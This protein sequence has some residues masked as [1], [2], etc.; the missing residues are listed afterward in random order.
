MEV[1]RL[2]DFLTVQVE[3]QSQTVFLSAKDV[4]ADGSKSWKDYT[5]QDVQTLSDKVSQL[6]LH[7]GLQKGDKIAIISANRPEWNFTDIGSQQLGIINVP[8]YP[9]IS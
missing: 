5:Y 6:L 2:F 8:M 1:K 4:Q 7:T 3:R 9:S